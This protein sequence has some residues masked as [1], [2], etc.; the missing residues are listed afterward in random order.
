M[1][2]GRVA[3]SNSKFVYGDG[4]VVLQCLSYL[5]EQ[6]LNFYLDL[7]AELSPSQGLLSQSAD[8]SPDLAISLWKRLFFFMPD[9]CE[10]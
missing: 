9:K 7:Y 1:K 8:S 10:Y 5:H 4:A 2:L 3:P 6:I